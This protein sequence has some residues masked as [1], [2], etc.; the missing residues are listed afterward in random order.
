MSKRAPRACKNEIFLQEKLSKYQTD[1]P[2]CP[3]CWHAYKSVKADEKE[4]K[5]QEKEEQKQNQP[6]VD[7][8]RQLLSDAARR[9]NFADKLSEQPGKEKQAAGMRT[10]A[11]NAM[12]KAV[13]MFQGLDPNDRAQMDEQEQDWLARGT[14]PQLSEYFTGEAQDPKTQQNEQIEKLVRERE[15]LCQRLTKFERELAATKQLSQMMKQELVSLQRV[16]KDKDIKKRLKKILED[17]ETQS[18]TVQ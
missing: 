9:G 5:R 18:P 15:H 17:A 12:G 3:T 13:Q 7:R 4:I 8:I 10:S 14:I 6:P 16:V 11:E 1:D 2:L